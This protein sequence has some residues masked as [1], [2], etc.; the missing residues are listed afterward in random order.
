ML[1]IKD[2]RSKNLFPRNIVKI[3]FYNIVSVYYYS[4]TEKTPVTW[5]NQT[6]RTSLYQHRIYII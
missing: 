2:I 3:G 5:G 4:T 1:Q 6:E